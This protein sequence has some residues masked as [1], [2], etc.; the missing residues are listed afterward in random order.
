MISHGREYFRFNFHKKDLEARFLLIHHLKYNVFYLVSQKTL[1]RA[2]FSDNCSILGSQ[3][4]RIA[5]KIYE[6]IE[7]MLKGIEPI[8]GGEFKNW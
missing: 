7:E 6:S 2:N 1:K 8:L 5:D 3:I 4:D